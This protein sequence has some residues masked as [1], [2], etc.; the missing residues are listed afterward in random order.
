MT[1]D[2]LMAEVNAIIEQAGGL[3]DAPET[4]AEGEVCQNCGEVHPQDEAGAL[5]EVTGRMKAVIKLMKDNPELHAEGEALT[6]ERNFLLTMK[7]FLALSLGSHPMASMAIAGNPE[8]MND[9]V[10]LTR[11]AFQLGYFHAKGVVLPDYKAGS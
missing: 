5:A 4:A 6:K 10:Q 2:E 8:V 3:P 9:L 7:A 1:E 11:G